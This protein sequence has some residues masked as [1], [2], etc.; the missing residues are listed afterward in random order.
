[1]L[2]R[3]GVALSL[4]RLVRLLISAMSVISMVL[5][6]AHTMALEVVVDN[7]LD[8][9]TSTGTWPVATGAHSHFG[10]I[11]RYAVVGGVVDTYRFTPDLPVAAEYEVFT[12]NSCSRPRYTTLPHLIVHADGERII[13][14]NQDC[15][16]GSA[17]EWFLLGRFNFAAGSAGFVEVSDAG[18]D[19]V[20]RNYMGADAVRFV[21]TGP[22][23]NL[24]PTVDAGA[25]QEVTA[26]L[27][28]QL[29]ASATDDGLPAQLQFSWSQQSGPPG[30]TFSAPGSAT[31]T[32]SPGGPGSY[33]VRVTVTDGELTAFDDVDV[34]VIA[35]VGVEIVVDNG[36]PGT[37]A[38][39]NWAAATGARSHFGA[40]SLY[41]LAGGQVDTYRFTPLLPVAGQYEVSAWNACSRPRLTDVP[42]TVAYAG[43]TAVIPV[44]QDCDR[45]SSGDWLV[46]GNWPFDAGNEG[47]VEISD[48][49]ADPLRRILGADAA[50]FV[51]VG[52]ALPPNLPP[53]VNA[54]PDQEVEETTIVM[55]AGLVTDDGTLLTTSWSQISGPGVASFTNP[56]ALSTTVSFDVAGV[57]AITLT[58]SDGTHTASDQV[59]VTVLPAASGDGD[60]EVVL[61]NGDPGTSSTGTWALATGARGHFGATSLYAVAGGQVDTYRFTPLLPTAGQYEV[62]AWNAC[63]R[64]RLAAV[65][66]TIAYAGSSVVISVN[67]DC[68]R[69]SAGEWLVLGTWPFAAGSLGYVEISDAGADPF[70]RFFGADA[71]RF[72]RVGSGPGNLPPVVSAGPDLAAT[73]GSS[74]WLAGS[75]SDDGD[76]SALSYQ[77]S[78]QSGPGVATFATP[79][80]AGSWVD[81]TNAG[82]Y[83]LQLSVSDGELD[84]EDDLT[85]QVGAPVNT[86][87]VVDAGDNQTVAQPDG[88]SLSATVTDDGLTGPPQLSW[89]ATGSGEVSFS[90]PAAAETSATFATAGQYVLRLTV[91]DGEFSSFDEVVIDVL[92]ALPSSG[93]FVD[94]TLAAACSDY[95]PA[96][97][98]CGGGTGFATPGFAEMQSDVAPGD[99]IFIR[100]GTYREALHMTRSGTPGS[101]ITWQAMPGEVVTFDGADSFKDGEEYGPLW[102]DH[103]DYVVVDGVRSVNSVGFGRLVG[104]H[105]NVVRNCDFENTRLGLG[106]ESKR[107]GLYVTHSSYNRFEGNLFA[108]GTDSLSLVRSDYNVIEGNTFRDAGHTTLALK[109]SSFNVVRGNTLSNTTQKTMELY[110]CEGATMRW[111]GNDDFRQDAVIVNAAQHNLVE[112]NRFELT[113]TNEFGPQ[114]TSDSSGIQYSGQDGIIRRNVFFNI[115]GPALGMQVY[116]GEAPFNTHNRLY[117]NVV[118]DS[119]CGAVTIRP[120]VVDNIYTNNIFCRERGL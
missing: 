60:D 33:T 81:F 17:G 92:A 93:R 114:S 50:R 117:H 68:D 76:I 75:A 71:V 43:G 49:G 35:D 31:T 104:A 29:S 9:T 44:N 25:D 85:V 67:Q 37:L 19:P 54:G 24:P 61:D 10:T 119:E 56:Q 36:D 72:V 96:A 110:D 34:E 59:A 8:G 58:V 78:Q 88:A 101:P 39:G 80:A 73:V 11:S 40:G 86:P 102:F 118:T 22:P 74:V 45:G 65:P 42:H 63:S 97:R 30:V 106:S 94:V 7:D 3:V 98:V 38:T 14:V 57:Y 53:V 115:L 21:T 32:M 47:Y 77:W 28:V 64:P 12:W 6:P 112:D 70:R 84:A 51:K 52:N 1:M 23:V 100:G 27:P 109:C 16:S 113:G 26:G 55:L 111:H 41:A 90:D 105:H 116:T 46:L 87:P 48:A 108:I 95:N 5:M 82:G 89:T 99:I 4:T 69:G 13:E 83:Q 91:F 2:K 103:V 79:T 107:G 66:H 120:N 15:D 18:L 62:A 20:L